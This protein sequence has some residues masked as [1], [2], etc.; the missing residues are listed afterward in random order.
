MDLHG[1]GS[2]PGAM[3]SQNQDRAIAPGNSG[4]RTLNPRIH[5]RNGFRRLFRMVHGRNACHKKIGGYLSLD[6]AF[7]GKLLPNL[8]DGMGIRLSAWN[9]R[10]GAHLIRG[11]PQKWGKFFPPN[12]KNCTIG[13]FE[14][15]KMFST[16]EGKILPADEESMKVSPYRILSFHFRRTNC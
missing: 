8:V 15:W 5:L 10:F 11:E 16:G 2:L 7:L 13:D 4:N 3:L 12:K 6:A 1:N 9:M 14:K